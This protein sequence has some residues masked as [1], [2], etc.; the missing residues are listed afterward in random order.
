MPPSPRAPRSNTSNPAVIRAD[1]DDSNMDPMDIF[2][3][4]VAAIGIPAV[5]YILL[6]ALIGGGGDS[7]TEQ[8]RRNEALE[9]VNPPVTF[10][11]I[12]MRIS[13][14]E[15]LLNNQV[16]DY[17]SRAGATDDNHV[18]NNWQELAYRV[19]GICK[20]ELE[21]VR[22]DIPKSAELQRHPEVRQAI[23]R[24]LA[25]IA[26]E[27]EKIRRTNPFPDRLAGAQ[28]EMIQDRKSNGPKKP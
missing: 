20:N 19:L 22:E 10:R 23:D 8:M 1:D 11:E 18:K 17:V 25:H 9:K 2:L 3:G 24:W 28:A 4:V 16:P 5:V 7:A 21:L 15:S 13:R 27:E 26:T 6:L 14:V 12:E